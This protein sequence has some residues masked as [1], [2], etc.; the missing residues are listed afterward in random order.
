MTFAAAPEAPIDRQALVS[1]H[2]PVITK[3]DVDAPLTVGNGG[4]A[5]G[6]DITGLQTFSEQHHML[7]IPVEIQ[8]RW[9][10]VTDEN[11]NKFTLADANREFT[12]ANGQVMGYPTK[13]STPTG[14]WIAEESAKSVA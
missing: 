3:F 12:N 8:S 6:A 1:R 5:F 11:P 7:G 10:W 9:C 4:F 14:D 2:N 13:S